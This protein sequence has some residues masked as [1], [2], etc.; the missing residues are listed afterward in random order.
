MATETDVVITAKWRDQASK[1]LKRLTK[2]LGDIRRLARPLAIAFVA[3]TA[4]LVAMVFQVAKL[5]DELQKTSI[6]TGVSVRT[7]SGLKVAVELAGGSLADLVTGFRGLSRTAGELLRGQLTETGKVLVDL[8]GSVEGKDIDTLFFEAADAIAAMS[9]ETEQLAV[10]NLIFG[11]SAIKILPL[12]KQGRV[13][14][15][16]TIEA[17]GRLGALWTR[18]SADAAAEFNDSVLI[19][20]TSFGGLAKDIV[21]RMLPALTNMARQ[22][23]DVVVSLGGKTRQGL[24]DAAVAVFIKIAQGVALVVTAIATLATAVLSAIGFIQSVLPS[25]RDVLTRQAGGLR[26]QIEAR[27]AGGVRGF[28]AAQVG[29]ITGQTGTI[30]ELQRQL[31]D[32]ENQLASMGPTAGETA[33]KIE[34]MNAEVQKLIGKLLQFVVQAGK[35]STSAEKLT[36]V[37]AD[38]PPGFSKA[39][40]AVASF[41]DKLKSGIL[42]AAF[43]P[44]A[45][46]SFSFGLAGENVLSQGIIQ[47]ITSGIGGTLTTLLADTIASPIQSLIGALFSNTDA[48]KEQERQRRLAA[49]GSRVQIAGFFGQGEEIAAAAQ[50]LAE[51]FESQL[52]SAGIRGSR[53][54]F[55]VAGL[56]VLD[57][58]GDPEILQRLRQFLVNEIRGLSE[59]ALGDLIENEDFISSLVS[60]AQIVD[61]QIAATNANTQAVVESTRAVIDAFSLDRLRILAGTASVLAGQIGLPASV[62]ERTIQQGGVA[63]GQARAG[64]AFTV[65]TLNI[66]LNGEVVGKMALRAVADGSRSNELRLTS[67]D[68]RKVTAEMN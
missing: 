6:A 11:R 52:A 3:V 24:G 67:S 66:A 19:L 59:G 34:A 12:L 23:A 30:P 13:A 5:G 37:V 48:I 2:L 60:L 63:L 36:K 43:I 31:A 65:P 54:P 1:G 46:Q 33:S 49:L 50:L 10:A 17:S 22:L 14:I 4:G 35:G 44:P 68:G 53:L 26:Q 58:K 20:K 27:Q 64:E 42:G 51:Q 32:V 62:R 57:P 45:G 25:D 9:S 39:E 8:V 61:G 18:E 40:K 56:S 55:T 16:E 21:V 15:E 47:G 38:L 41:N 29:G 28:L 7:L